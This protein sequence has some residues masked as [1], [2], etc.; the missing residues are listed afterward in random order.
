[1]K[2]Q[3]VAFLFI[4]AV[5]LLLKNKQSLNTAIIFLVLSTILFASGNLF[6]AQ[7]FTWYA[8]AF[9]LL[10]IVTKVLSIS[11]LEKKNKS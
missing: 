10:D 2:S 7:R 8:A 5:V 3:D 1:M 9:I 6:T 4:F 11:S